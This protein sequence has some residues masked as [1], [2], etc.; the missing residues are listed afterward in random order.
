MLKPGSA[1]FFEQ[2]IALDL[3]LSYSCVMISNCSWAH[4]IMLLLV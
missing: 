3:V 4:C 2:N 1:R